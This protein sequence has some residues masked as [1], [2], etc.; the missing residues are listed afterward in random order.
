VDLEG[1]VVGVNSAIASQ[2]GFYSG[3]GF[4]VP[5]N[6][7]RRVA[8][9][10]IEH[11][12]ARRPMIGVQ[13]SDVEPV[14]VDVYRLPRAAGA[15][16]VQ[17]T[18]GSPAAEAGLRLGDVVVAVNG[19]AVQWSADLT[20]RLALLQ[21]GS[22]ARLDVIRYGERRQVTV[23]LGEF[24]TPRLAVSA[25]RREPATSSARLGFAVRQLNPS[26]AE[27]LS[28]AAGQGVAIT[29]IAAGSPA[30]GR[31]VT[32]MVVEQLNGQRIQDVS[33]LEQAAAGL[34]PGAA[35]SLIVIDPTGER[36]IVN[37]RARA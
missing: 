12:H 6:L 36:R 3:Y 35:V 34:R 32:G 37:Y 24:A 17:V 31:L 20:E 18:P 9:D 28:A 19:E 16:V 14:D 23:E 21:P 30:E 29:G 7:A 5:A 4:A 1:R 26:L 22:R 2:T 33:D 13:V 27:R 11:G 10:L 25:P 15:E 8:S